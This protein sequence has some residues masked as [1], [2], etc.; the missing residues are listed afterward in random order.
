[1]GSVSIAGAT[2][3]VRLTCTGAPGQRCSGSL[4]GTVTEQLRGR[5][6]VAVTAAARPTRHP[7]LT[8]KALLVAT[9]RYDV[10]AGHAATLRITANAAG[11]KLL[12][13]FYTLP[14]KLVFADP[15]GLSATI[16]FAYPR[17]K[18][19]VNDYWTLTLQPCGPCVTIVHQLT[20]SGL[21]S[22]P[23]I[24]VSCSGVGCPF[25]RKVL[26]PR[27]R[28]VALAGMF[29]HSRLQAG[30]KLEIRIT[31]PNRVGEALLYTIRSGTL[32]RAA[33]RCLPPGA[34]VPVACRAG[35]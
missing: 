32:P 28:P 19:H 11:R 33:T 15:T 31:A 5:S 18:P 8:A 2:A 24:T 27:H 16:T 9:G 17:V 22:G 6:I 26:K 29:V 14:T 10:Q 23:Q 1:V 12:L 7:A 30:T 13:R 21:P 35:S 34:R 25:G 4:R 20:L 3:N